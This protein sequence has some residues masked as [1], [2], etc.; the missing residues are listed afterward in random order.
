MTSGAP[1][2]PSSTLFQKQTSDLG[3]PRGQLTGKQWESP[4]CPWF[5]AE[6]LPS[7]PPTRS[8]KRTAG[9]D[10]AVAFVTTDPEHRGLQF[11]C[12]Q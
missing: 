11:S 5:P 7:S 1:L 6:R 4:G 9:S 12:S 8:T 3:D 2:V 10:P